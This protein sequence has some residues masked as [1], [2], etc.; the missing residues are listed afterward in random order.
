MGA[1]MYTLLLL[2]TKHDGDY[3]CVYEDPV[4][5]VSRYRM[6]GWYEARNGT[7]YGDTVDE[8]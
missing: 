5:W 4:G 2:V 1:M 7:D 8:P 3:L 6:C